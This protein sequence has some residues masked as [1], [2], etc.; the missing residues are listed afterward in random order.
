MQ[1]KEFI[2]S[3]RQIKEDSGFEI[4]KSSLNRCL[5]EYQKDVVQWALKKGSAAVFADT[6][7]GKTIMQC[8]WA[9]L[10]CEK[11]NLPVLI[12]A[13]LCIS[14]QTQKESLEVLGM[15][16]KRYEKDSFD[17]KNG[18]YVT[19]YEQIRNIDFSE[20]IG[21]VL[22][23]SSILKHRDSK[24]RLMI[25]GNIK[26]IKY[27]LSLTATPAPNDY[28]EFG[29]QAEFLNVMS[30]ESMW[31]TFFINDVKESSKWRLK[32]HCQED[33]WAW[34]SSWAVIFR[35]PSDIGHPENDFELPKLNYETVVVNSGMD[36]NEYLDRNGM[37]LLGRNRARRDTIEHRVDRAV[38]IV[39]Q[40]KDKCDEP[41][42]IWCNLNDESQMIYE[43]LKN[44][45]MGVVEVSGQQKDEVK[46]QGLIGFSSGD[47]SILITKPKIAGFGMNWQHC[48]KM[49][50]IGLNDS[51]EQL[52][53]AVRRC[54][55][56]GQSQEVTAYLITAD[57]EN[58]VLENINLKDEKMK[59]MYENIIEHMKEFQ[60]HGLVA[61][62]S[63][64][65]D[66]SNGRIERD[67]NFEIYNGDC[68][69]YVSSLESNS[70]DYSIFSPPFAS[71]YTY[72]DD[73]R[74]MGNSRSDDEF[75]KH[76]D[77]MI[78]ELY[79]V[80]AEGRLVSIHCMNLPT[81]KSRHG[82]IG[83]RDFRGDIIR[84]MQNHGFI[85]A[86]EVTIWKCPVVAMQRTKALGLLWKQIKK[87]SAMNRQGIPDYLMTFRKNGLNKKPVSHTAE[88][89]PVDRWQNLAQPTWQNIR[90]SNTL[91]FKHARDD[92]DE[93]HICPLQLDLIERCL[94]LWTLPNDTVL[95][96]FTGIGSEGV[97][98]LEMGRKFKGSELKPSYF[99]V[100][101]QNLSESSGNVKRLWPCDDPIYD[102]TE[103]NTEKNKT[104]VD[105]VN[106]KECEHNLFDIMGA[107]DAV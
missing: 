78:K 53:Q 70:I 81:S 102:R 9:R 98:S 72:S 101:F 37:G 84:M 35:R 25:M 21:I 90:Q 85:Y 8:E 71:L 27:R 74:D 13:P 91:N 104:K 3:K 95:S 30:Q 11:T 7:L 92:R 52:Y 54:Y 43:K 58:A 14:E 17:G 29:S 93:R 88:Q 107:Q 100:A 57:I 73:D 26:H 46:R 64:L 32:K 23:E 42:L 97:V 63:S 20:F 15:E 41:V 94:E 89:F 34:V 45:F 80:M 68:V 55:R 82:F 59:F 16:I 103:K 4:N 96:P 65:D 62:T 67:D 56:F 83:I 24:T 2:E 50:F 5:F 86:S 47:Y 66:K 99:D 33:F 28:M 6:G 10:V 49:I 22:D 76:F 38:E 40:I 69:D 77:F 61:K 79:R 31:A 75:Y 51:Y 87:D 44:K 60:S 48:N 12:L 19:N 18:V 106:K 39:S 1:Y 36:I 105:N